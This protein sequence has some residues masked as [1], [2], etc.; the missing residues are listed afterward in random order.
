MFSW[1]STH[2]GGKRAGL[3]TLQQ[4]LLVAMHP[5]FPAPKGPGDDLVTPKLGPP[6]LAAIMEEK[7]G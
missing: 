2:S 5:A 6:A 7:Q 3:G 4:Q 1:A